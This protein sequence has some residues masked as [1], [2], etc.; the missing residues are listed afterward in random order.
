MYCWC[1]IIR[2]SKAES[3]P[4]TE[5]KK[6]IFEACYE[7]GIITDERLDEAVKRVLATQHKAMEMA[8]SRAKELTEEEIYLAKHINKDSVYARFDE[9][10]TASISREGRHFFALMTRN[11][12]TVRDGKVEVDTFNNGWLYPSRVTAKIKELF[13]NSEV[14]AYHQFPRQIH[15]MRILSNSIGFDDIIFVTF[16]EALAYMGPEHLTRRVE[17]LITAAQY[18]NRISTLVHFG[19][20]CVLENLPHIPRYIFGGLSEESVNTC[21]EVLAGEYEPKGVPTYKFKLN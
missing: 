8:K 2:F 15:N 1:I 7:Q 3:A 11:E 5:R 21:L 14:F 6:I 9:G 4:T 10:L 16:S 19:N 12:E 20:P 13:P 18:T 17:T